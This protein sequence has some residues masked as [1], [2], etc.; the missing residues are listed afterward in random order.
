M[1]PRA[2]RVMA[3][4]G[5]LILPLLTTVTPVHGLRLID[6]KLLFEISDQLSQPSDVAVSNDGRIYVVD[7]VNSKVR[8]FNPSGQ[9]IASF[10]TAGSGN[11]E[12]KNPLG[13]D[14]DRSG[15]VYIADSGNHRVQIF[16]RDGNFIA[17]IEMHS[18][19]KH[20]PDPTDVAV[21]ESRNRCYVVDNDNHQI[22]VYD[23]A[24]LKLINTYGG[25]G[26]EKRAFRY[27]FLVA[28]DKA[29]YLYIVDVINT[30]IQVLNP[31]GLFVNF[32][33][34]WGVEKGELYRPKGVALDQKDRIY[35]SDSY[36][37]VIQIFDSTGEF[38][39]AVGEPAKGRVKKFKT[40]VGIFLDHRD[41]LYVVE[42]FANKVSVYHLAGIS[43][44]N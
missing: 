29:Q 36:M 2:A 27:P 42:M 33:G 32:I 9:T 11:G 24:N 10:G 40:P 21:D 23:L 38:Y 4:W 25:P 8:I 1:V 28:L 22:L 3:F 30:R 31:E 18:T 19:K 39:A 12:F 6:A 37:G 41:R 20:P 16:D 14:I 43:K 7:G 17:A 34:A 15:R 5:L 35:V 44:S 13:I 26:S